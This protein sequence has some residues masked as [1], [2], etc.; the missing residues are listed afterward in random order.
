LKTTPPLT[1]AAPAP[2]ERFSVTSSR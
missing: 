1:A 2:N